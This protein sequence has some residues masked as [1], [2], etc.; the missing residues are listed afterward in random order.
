M[1]YYPIMPI[2]ASIT[3]QVDELLEEARA[4]RINAQELSLQIVSL[5]LMSKSAE[6]IESYLSSF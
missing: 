2:N 4:G 6:E 3:E 1:K 5:M